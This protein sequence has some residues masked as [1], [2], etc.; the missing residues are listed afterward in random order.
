MTI[1]VIISYHVF[2][3]AYDIMYVIICDIAYDIKHNIVIDIIG[4]IISYVY[5]I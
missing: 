2:D 5:M 4:I 3:N 1:V